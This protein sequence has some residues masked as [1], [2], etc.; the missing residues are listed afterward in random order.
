MS[1][2]VDATDPSRFGNDPILS[3]QWVKVLCETKFLIRRKE[4]KIPAKGSQAEDKQVRKRASIS[5]YINS[6]EGVNSVP[7]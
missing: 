3:F 6:R 1:V 4:S 5:I 2:T 7:R